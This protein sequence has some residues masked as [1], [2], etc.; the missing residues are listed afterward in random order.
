MGRVQLAL[1]VLMYAAPPALLLVAALAFGRALAE[2]PAAVPAPLPHLLALTAAFLTVTKAPKLL[3][4]LAV[5]LDRNE[6]RRFG[7]QGRVAATALTE[8]AFSILLTPVVLLSQGLFVLG[9]LAGRRVGW[10]LHR[11]TPRRL[12]WGETALALWPHVT[13]GLL[14]PMACALRAPNLLPAALA[15]GAWLL[16]GLPFAVFTARSSPALL[17]TRLAATPEELSPPPAVR[18]A[19]YGGFEAPAGSGKPAAIVPSVS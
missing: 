6:A 12:H 10:G 16:A 18:E 4:T 11:R 15:F 2:G 9:M 7:G 17:R 19:G 8:L 3:G 13:L 5:L 14:L 1:A